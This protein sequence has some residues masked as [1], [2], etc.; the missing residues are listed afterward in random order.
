VFGCLL[1]SDNSSLVDEM[2]LNVMS[3]LDVKQCDDTEEKE[4]GLIVAVGLN[5]SIDHYIVTF[6]VS[7]LRRCFFFF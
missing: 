5:N 1:S 3:L 4:K 6:V 7:C 2:L